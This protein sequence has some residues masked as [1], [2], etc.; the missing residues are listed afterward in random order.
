MT[1]VAAKLDLSHGSACQ[2]QLRYLASLYSFEDIARN[3][4]LLKPSTDLRQA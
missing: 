4:D 2:S 3:A 1:P